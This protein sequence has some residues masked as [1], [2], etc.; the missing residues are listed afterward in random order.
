MEVPENA[1]NLPGFSTAPEVLNTFKDSLARSYWSGLLVEEVQ[2]TAGR[3]TIL[4]PEHHLVAVHLGSA[5]HLCQERAGQVSRERLTHGD[6]TLTP[7]GQADQRAWDSPCHAIH[8]WIAQDYLEQIA[9]ATMPSPIPG[10]DTPTVTLQSQFLTRD[11]FLENMAAEF[12]A[13]LSCAREHGEAATPS[14]YAESLRNVFAAHLLRRF[15]TN[16]MN[17]TKDA[18]SAKLPDA[19]LQKLSC[20][21]AGH[22]EDDLTL[23]RLANAMGISQFHLARLFKE[24]SGLTLHQFVIEAR[25]EQAKQLLATGS[26]SAAEVA[27]RVGFGSQSLLN[28][29]FKRLVGTTPA[30]F[31]RARRRR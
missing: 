6:I 27:Y 13:I 26:G 10:E 1:D 17:N 16:R 15:G 8:F 18:G 28:R 25:I 19:V 4:A 24:A 14:L 23:P 22:L 29:H 7:A 31:A 12:Q 20:F 21:V 2:Y 30:A 3:R 11:L 5:V 9:R